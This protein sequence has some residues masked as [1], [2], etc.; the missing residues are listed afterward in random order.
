MEFM[1]LYYSIMQYSKTPLVEF[2]I[3]I[4]QNIRSCLAKPDQTVSY[5]WITLIMINISP[6]K[7][8]YRHW[9][10]FLGICLFIHLLIPLLFPLIFLFISFV[11]FLLLNCSPYYRVAWEQTLQ[12]GKGKI[13]KGTR[14][15]PF[16]PTTKPGPR[17][18][19]RI[20]LH[21][22]SVI[23]FAR[24]SHNTVVNKYHLLYRHEFYW[25]IYHS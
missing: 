24:L 14:F 19:M 17:L 7:F 4:S 8:D 23:R 2:A 10:V 20:T 1:L 22:H 13:G 25:K 21:I 16:T 6:K 12:W 11:F 3:L 5:M 18:V 9:E 15:V